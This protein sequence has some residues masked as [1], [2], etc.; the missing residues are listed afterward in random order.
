MIQA[1]LPIEYLYQPP[2]VNDTAIQF[3][4]FNAVILIHRK[5]ELGAATRCGLVLPREWGEWAAMGSFS[6]HLASA[7]DTVCE[8]CKK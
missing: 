7:P 4:P 2:V 8:E 5:A 6:K 3:A 1:S